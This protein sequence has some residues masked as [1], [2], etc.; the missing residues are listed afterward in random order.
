MK[1]RKLGR[2]GLDVSELALGGVFVQSTVTPAE[3]VRAIVQC[4]AD[5]GINLVDTAPAYGDSEAALG[6]ALE[7]VSGTP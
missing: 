4:A 3:D 1:K 2:T 7:G 5:G 6:V